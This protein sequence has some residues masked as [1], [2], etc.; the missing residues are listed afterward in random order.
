MN[1]PYLPKKWVLGD[2]RSMRDGAL[3]WKLKRTGAVALVAGPILASPVA[4]E[5]ANFFN[6]KTVYESYCEACH[7]ISGQGEMPG[8]PNFSQGRTLM[9]PDLSIYVRIRDGANAMPGF[10]GILSET[11][12]LDVISYI[13]SFY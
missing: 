7:G 5:A 12:I 1:K 4:V 13:R 11:E 2:E 10:R 9:Q 6:G 8:A 3:Q